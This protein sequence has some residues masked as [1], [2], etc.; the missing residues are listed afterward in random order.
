MQVTLS[1]ALDELQALMAGLVSITIGTLFR[2]L[3]DSHSAGYKRTKQD[4]AA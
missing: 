2:G 4:L 3:S 1:A